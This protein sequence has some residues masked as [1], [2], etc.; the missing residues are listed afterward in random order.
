MTKIT[1]SNVD[2]IEAALKAVN[3]KADRHTFTDAIDIA[4]AATEAEQRLDEIGI[5]KADRPGTFASVWSGYDLPNSYKYQP[6]RTMIVIVRRTAGWYLDTITVSKNHLKV[7]RS[8]LTISAGAS[9]RAW[10]RT[11]RNA[12]V[13]IYTPQAEDHGVIEVQ[14]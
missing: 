14:L 13:D 8:R 2:R 6:Q 11:L 10:A 5:L 1:D 4:R 12:G 7:P 9:E 3:G